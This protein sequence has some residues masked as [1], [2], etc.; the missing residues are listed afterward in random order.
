MND[1]RTPPHNLAAEQGLLGAVL[2]DNRLLER[3]STLRPDHFFDP[4]HSAIWKSVCDIVAG[5]G[6]ADPVTLRAAFSDASPVGEMS[7]T[8]YIA[9][10]ATTHACMPSSIG[11]YAAQIREMSL[12]RQIVVLAEDLLTIAYDQSNGDRF[13]ELLRTTASR[14]HDLLGTS[15]ASAEVA[16]SDAVDQALDAANSAYQRQGALAGIPTGL[17]DLDRQMGGLQASDL[18]VL[19]GR[20]AMGKTAMA[21]NI[22][23]NTARGTGNDPRTGEAFNPRHVHFF[24]QEMSAVQLAMRV[25][26]D[27]TEVP[28]DKLRRGDV[29]EGQI[30]GVLRQRDRLKKIPMTIDESGGITLAALAQKARRIKRRYDTG[31]IIIDYIQLMSGSMSGGSNRVQEITAITTGLKALAKELNVPIIALSQLSRKVEERSD[32]RPQLADLRESGSIEQDADVVLFVYR[33][34][35]YLHR[36][37]PDD[38][39]FEEHAK[40]KDRM[41][42]AA[43]KAEVIIAKHRHAP[44]GVVELSFQAALTRF[45]NLARETHNGH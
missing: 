12:R 7:A 3:V 45:S 1:Q 31:L 38:T 26:A 36:E 9:S 22:A 39:N 16:F 5:N 33:D 40:W 34:D 15:G 17:V 42:R 23:V 20:P 13:P 11:A 37:E 41:D 27:I 24:S 32:K 43:G 18:I 10:L 35:Y 28:G 30:T 29:T 44:T 2:L 14:L 4:M 19:A 6:R 21:T 25:I 8:Q